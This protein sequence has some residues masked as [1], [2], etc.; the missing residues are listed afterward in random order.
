MV[1]EFGFCFW[2]RRGRS[3]QKVSYLVLSNKSGTVLLCAN[4]V[5]NDWH[6]AVINS[7]EFATLAV[8][9]TGTVNVEAYLV[10]AAGA[11]IHFYTKRGNCSAV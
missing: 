2:K 3:S 8:E 1:Y 5:N 7:A 6:E 4:A 11:A 9:G 10:K